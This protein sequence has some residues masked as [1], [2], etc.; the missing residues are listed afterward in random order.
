MLSHL[1]QNGACT[2]LESLVTE[3]KS[4]LAVGMLVGIGLGLNDYLELRKYGR[5]TSLDN[6]M[7]VIFPSYLCGALGLT[8]FIGVPLGLAAFVVNEQEKNKDFLE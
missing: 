6:T 2:F 3:S 8:P 7:S 4:G 1:C 5:H